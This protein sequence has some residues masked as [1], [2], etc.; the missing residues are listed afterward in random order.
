MRLVIFVDICNVEGLSFVCL[1]S[2]LNNLNKKYFYFLLII[3]K[4]DL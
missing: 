1:I 3:F 2:L 4:Y